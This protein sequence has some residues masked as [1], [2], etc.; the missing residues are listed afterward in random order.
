MRFRWCNLGEVTFSNEDLWTN[1]RRCTNFLF[2]ALLFKVGAEVSGTDGACYERPPTASAG[3]GRDV[4][5][6]QLVN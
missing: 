3:P 6:L 1:W 4:N 5:N 2:P